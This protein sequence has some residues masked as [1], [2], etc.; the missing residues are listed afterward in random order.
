MKKTIFFTFTICSLLFGICN[1]QWQPDVRLTNDAGGSNTSNNNAWCIA[2]NG[3]EVHVTWQDNRDGNNEI[4][5]KR[6]TDGGITWTTDTRLTNNSASSGSS[7]ISVSG[8]TVHIILR[9][10]RDGNDEIYYK[11]STDSG[12]NWGV[13][14]RLTN[15]TSVS[16]SPSLAVSGLMVHVVW[17]DQRDGNREIYYKRSTDAGITWGTDNRLTNNPD[18]AVNASIGIFGSSVYVVWD[19]DRDNNNEIYFKL[20]TDNGITWG[21]DT[22]LTNDAANSVLPSIAVTGSNLHVVWHDTRNGTN[23]VYY[24]RSTDGGSTWGTDTRLSSNSNTQVFPSVAVSGTTVHVVW[25]D[26][27][28]GNYEIYNKRSTN[29]G[30]LWGADTRLTNASG[31]SSYPSVSLSG[32][33]V[34]V[35]WNDNRDGNTEIYYKRDPTGNVVG[36]T[37]INSE[38]PNS[39][40]L[41]QNYPNPFNPSTKIQFAL[42]KSSF[43]TLVVYDA[44]GRELETLVSELLTAGTYEADWNADKFSSGVY[45]YKL[46]AGDYTETRKMVLMK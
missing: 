5:Y 46:T 41:S 6:S 32:S 20:S 26:L 45:Y 7:S 10:N 27:R 25:Y 31:T 29:S 40:S 28:D 38:L 4:Y 19:D 23:K 11:R 43:A 14:T 42:P 15:F 30:T 34:H 1:A 8:T 12:V 9:D 33:A 36:I 2:A 44:L 22:R 16:T 18:D 37:N 24:K 17:Y 13:D 35:V 21:S 3:N 39:F